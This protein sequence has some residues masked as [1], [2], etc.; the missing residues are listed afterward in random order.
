M[1]DCAPVI[2]I[3][4]ASLLAQHTVYS[5]ILIFISPHLMLLSTSKHRHPDRQP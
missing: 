4:P 5:L 1:M 3:F 2:T